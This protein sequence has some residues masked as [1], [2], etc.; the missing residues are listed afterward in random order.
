L[1]PEQLFCAYDTPDDL[2]PLIEAGKKLYRA[3]F[4]RRHCRCYVLIGY[5]KD[6]LDGAEQRLVAAWCAGFMPMAMLWA[7]GGEQSRDWK[8]LQREWARP[9]ITRNRVRQLLETAHA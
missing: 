4:T 8:T 1:R 2:E 6:T 9:A 3:D 7:D 5:P